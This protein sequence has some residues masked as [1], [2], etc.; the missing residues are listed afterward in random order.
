[1]EKSRARVIDTRVLTNWGQKSETR[2]DNGAAPCTQKQYFSA[3]RWNRQGG[4]SVIIP[5]GKM[6]LV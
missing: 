1:M 3:T 4:G 6:V 2:M 5:A